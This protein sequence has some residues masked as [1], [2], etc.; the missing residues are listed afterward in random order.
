[1]AEHKVVEPN[2][3]RVVDG[4]RDTGY[5][6]EASIADLVD[7]SI[8]AGS[9]VIGIEV[10]LTADGEVLVQVA[11]NGCGMDLEGLENAMRYGS[12]RKEDPHRL[13]RFGLGLKTASTSFCRRLTVVSS[14][15]PIESSKPLAATWDL[16]VIAQQNQWILTLGEADANESDFF[17]DAMEALAH[18]A[19]SEVSSGTVVHWDK[20]DRLLR[21]QH[22]GAYKN[23]ESA[24]ARRIGRLTTHLG[25]VFQRFLDPDDERGRNI[26]IFVNGGRIVPW[27]PFCEVFAEVEA[28]KVRTWAIADGSGNHQGEIVLRAFILP[29]A[30]EVEDSSYPGAAQISN[31]RQG[32]YVYR[33]NRLIEGPDWLTIGAA[34][35]H[36][37]RLRV[38]LSFPAPLDPF[39]GVGIKKSGLHLDPGL[40]EELENVLTPVRREADRRN[41]RGRAKSAA[42]AGTGRRPADRTIDS[43]KEG[44]SLP[45]TTKGGDG[46]LTMTNNLVNELKVLGP[47]GA[48]NPEFRIRIEDDAEGVHIVHTESLEDGVLWSPSFG[49]GAGDTK[50]SINTSHDWY[51]KAYLP[52]SANSPLTQAIEFLLFALAQAE[53]NNTRLDLNEVF[54]VF[55]IEVSRNL[56]HLVADLPEPDDAEE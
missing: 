5:S 29:P 25:T 22:G 41:R 51:R 15:G 8:E 4:F 7:N 12:S 39:F 31:D 46:S 44:L 38:E 42:T 40:F 9:S 1:M 48:P 10:N 54:E 50:V 16:D 49:K 43:E 53:M 32:I 56:R 21:K 23:P 13:G 33:E 45:S 55:R 11:D 30:N 20:V 36:L 35:T 19:E 34:D 27:D 47:G 17:L 14:E 52:N 3:A 37:N 2:T 24:L 18:G 26:S 6:F 28:E